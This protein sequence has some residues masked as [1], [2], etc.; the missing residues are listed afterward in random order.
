M[1]AVLL[2]TSFFYI[3]QGAQASF[4]REIS[5]LLGSNPGKSL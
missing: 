4:E 1:R 5:K 2:E 3:L